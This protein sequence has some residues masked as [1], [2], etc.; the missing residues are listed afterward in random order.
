MQQDIDKLLKI[1][2]QEDDAPLE[3]SDDVIDFIEFYKL[4]RGRF[5]VRYSTLKRLY[6]RWSRD[7]VTKLTFIKRMNTHIPSIKRRYIRYYKI[8]RN[9]LNLTREAYK[10]I[11]DN[12]TKSRVHVVNHKKALEFLKEKKIKPGK[13][14]PIGFKVIYY[15]FLDWCEAKGMKLVP[16][17]YRSFMGLMKLTYDSKLDKKGELYMM[18]TRNLRNDYLTPQRAAAIKRYYDKKEAKKS[19][20][21]SEVPSTES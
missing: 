21:K 8:N 14:F 2:D 9:S 20:I 1:L 12:K 5:W 16:I 19:K 17:G 4:K 6:D 11:N 7:S 10:F 3:Y 15:M 13:R 18:V